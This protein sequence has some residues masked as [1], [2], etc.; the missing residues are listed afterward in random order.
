[1]AGARVI[2]SGGKS[3]RYRSEQ[4]P[5]KTLTPLIIK[6]E[7]RPS[8]ESNRNPPALYR[9]RYHLILQRKKHRNFILT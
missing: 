2:K 4:L 1:M 6:F 9:Q 3:K 5:E 8:P 7:N